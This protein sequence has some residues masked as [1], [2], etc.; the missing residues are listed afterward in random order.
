MTPAPAQGR[1]ALADST[2]QCHASV[3]MATF[4]YRHRKRS[5]RP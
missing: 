1:V 4:G 2:R 3:V 5:N